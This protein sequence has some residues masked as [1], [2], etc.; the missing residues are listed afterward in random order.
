MKIGFIGCG[1]MGAALAAAAAKGEKK[2]TMLFANRTA[3][4]AEQLA[5][6]IGGSVCENEQLVR[7]S[8]FVFLGVKPQQL[9]QLL[10]QM[11]PVLCARVAAGAAPVLVSMAA[12]ITL[13]A[14]CAQLGC[15]LPCIRI[16]PNTPAA[17]GAGGLLYCMRDVTPAQAEQFLVAMAP[18]GLLL[19]MEESRFDAASAISGCGPAFCYM[20]ADA[21]AM[22]GVRCGLP[23]TDACRLAAQTM[24][25]AAQML[26]S[27]GESPDTLKIQVCSPAGTTIEGVSALQQ[28]AFAYTVQSAVT[29]ACARSAA[30]AK[31][32]EK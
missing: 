30:L 31:S 16:M 24:L 23:Y 19:P 11:E 22:G 12:G 9:P 4:K 14:L 25:G 29:A 17:V 28:G 10:T 7:Q 1:H 2:P 18:A 15:R 6:R 5:E 13:D 27:S 32:K 21:L 26:L 3:A 8:D 20:F